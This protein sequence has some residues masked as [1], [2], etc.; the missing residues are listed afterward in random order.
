MLIR[1]DNNDFTFVHTVL[2]R[3][4]ASNDDVLKKTRAVFPP[5]M[6]SAVRFPE[7]LIDGATV[8]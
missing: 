6:A 4:P 3:P 1:D 5:G 7:Q 8:S 2:A